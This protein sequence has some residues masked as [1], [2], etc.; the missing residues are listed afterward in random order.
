ML[1]RCFNPRA[2]EGRDQPRSLPSGRCRVSIH[3]PARGATNGAGVSW[4]VEQC[5]N[6][7]AREGRDIGNSRSK[8]QIRLFQST[9][10]R[11][12]R[13]Y[14][15][16]V[17]YISIIV[18]IHAP[19]RGATCRERL[20]SSGMRTFQSTRPRGARLASCSSADSRTHVSIHAPAR[21]ATWR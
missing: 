20:Q 5:F 12:A 7:R 18:S 11:G 10:P 19:A 21:G 14:F 4:H 2:R 13:H 17:Y 1:L 15:F 6:P 9:R 8:L 3:A 16:D